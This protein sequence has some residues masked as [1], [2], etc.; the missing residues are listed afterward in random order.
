MTMI[1][2]K[3][4][5]E[6]MLEFLRAYLTFAKGATSIDTATGEHNPF[7]FTT[8]FGLCSAIAEYTMA[9]EHPVL[10]P[11]DFYRSLDNMLFRRMVED[12]GV[13]FVGDDSVFPFGYEDYRIRLQNYTQHK[14]PKRLG[15]IRMFIKELEIECAN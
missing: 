5:N 11:E 6:Y 4:L 9:T 12:A 8:R 1:A 13:N 15:F 10:Q 14:C 7:H 2:C 3:P